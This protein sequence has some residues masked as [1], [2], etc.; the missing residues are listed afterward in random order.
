MSTLRLGII[1]GGFCGSATAMFA[2]ENNIVKTYDIC[3][4]RCSAGVSSLADLADCDMVFIC[5]NTPMIESSGECYVGLVEKVIQQ[6]RDTLPSTCTIVVRSTVPVG[7]SKKHGTVAFCEYLTEANWKQDVLNT[8]EWIVGIN[9]DA[10]GTIKRKFEQMFMN[11]F[12]ST[13]QTYISTD[14]CEMIKY[15][16]NCFLATKVSFCN[17]IESFCRAKQVSYDIVR[18]YAT[19]D[20]RVGTSHTIVPGPDGKRGFSGSCFPKD[21]ASLRFQMDQEQVPSH[22]ISAVITRNT[23]IDR[24]DQDWKNEKGRAVL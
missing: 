22:V 14:E 15:M 3:A 13:T 19:H 16:R 7:F 17:E 6:C 24:N 1:G 4:E 9:E 8:K 10:S 12:P 11:R 20:S 18:E 23:T 21:C 5:V 2:C